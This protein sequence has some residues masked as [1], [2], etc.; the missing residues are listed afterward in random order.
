MPQRGSGPNAPNTSISGRMRRKSRLR[1][2]LCLRLKERGKIGERV[3][4]T[5]MPAVL[6][7][8]VYVVRPPLDEPGDGMYAAESEISPFV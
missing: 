6:T 5:S 2:D 8:L 4:V 7:V 3:P 1:L